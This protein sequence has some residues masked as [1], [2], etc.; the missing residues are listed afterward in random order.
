MG[1]VSMAFSFK[2]DIWSFFEGWGWFEYRE[3]CD[4][5]REEG[6]LTR[7]FLSVF[8]NVELGMGNGG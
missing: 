7:R 2:I 1:W 5:Y 8:S 6:I 3:T 4:V